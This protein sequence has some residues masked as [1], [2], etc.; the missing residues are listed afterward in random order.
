MGL[1][2]L[3]KLW[4]LQDQ[5]SCQHGRV[6]VYC[7]SLWNASFL[8]NQSNSQYP[9]VQNADPASDSLLSDLLALGIPDDV[10]ETGELL[11]LCHDIVTAI[12]SQERVAVDTQGALIAFRVLE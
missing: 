1:K 5:L 9:I 6:N 3:R 7:K 2:V 8:S 10:P 12:I 4:A 11:P